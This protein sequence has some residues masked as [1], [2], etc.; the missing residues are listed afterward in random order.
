ML[1]DEIFSDISKPIRKYLDR[2]D[3]LDLC[4]NKI[5]EV[6]IYTQEGWRRHEAPEVTHEWLSS[7]IRVASNYSL[8]STDNKS[9]LLSTTL[10]SGERIQAAIKPCANEISLTIRKPSDS[11]FTL[12]DLEKQGRFQVNTNLLTSTDIL[13]EAKS[14]VD[15]KKIREFLEFSVKKLSSKLLLRFFIS[16]KF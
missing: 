5:G 13:K 15:S 8:Q 7:F 6:Y 16:T 4:V 14:L 1:T 3:L 11:L 12:D 10:I 9:P 2:P